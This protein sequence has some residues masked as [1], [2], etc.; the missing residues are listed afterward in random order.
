MNDQRFDN[1]P[2]I[3]ETPDPTRWAE[4]ISW[5]YGLSN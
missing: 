5:L 4:E 1:M 2:I 3:L